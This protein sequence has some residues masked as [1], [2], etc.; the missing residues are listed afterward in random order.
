M[1]HTP[2]ASTPAPK[3]DDLTPRDW[4]AIGAVAATVGLSGIVLGTAFYLGTRLITAG[5]TWLEC[6]GAATVSLLAVGLV[7]ANL[8]R[9]A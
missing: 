1:D 7:I 4:Q 3:N 2:G 8:A 5:P 9:R 6:I